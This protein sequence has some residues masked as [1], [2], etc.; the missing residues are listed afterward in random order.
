MCVCLHSFV[1]E[2]RGGL[3]QYCNRDT[4]ILNMPSLVLRC[5]VKATLSARP[6]EALLARDSCS[7]RSSRLDVVDSLLISVDCKRAYYQSSY[8]FL[9]LRAPRTPHQLRHRCTYTPMRRCASTPS[10]YATSYTIGHR[11]LQST[12]GSMQST[13]A[14]RSNAKHAT[15]GSMAQRVI[16]IGCAGQPMRITRLHPR[17]IHSPRLAAVT[18]ASDTAPF[19]TRP[20]AQGSHACTLACRSGRPVS[21]AGLPVAFARAGAAI[22]ATGAAV[23]TLGFK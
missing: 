4:C 13:A 8:I 3:R 1:L 14:W 20:A 10:Q 2:E 9:G 11:C 21:G 17:A 22:A 6:S 16:R 19:G 12:A 15:H 23:Y 7:A 18:T 5:V